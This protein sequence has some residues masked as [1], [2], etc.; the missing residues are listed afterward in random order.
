MR[1]VSNLY[2]TLQVCNTNY[3]I[4]STFKA[5]NNPST[6]GLIRSTNRCEDSVHVQVHGVD[7][8]FKQQT[9]RPFHGRQNSN[10]AP[11]SAVLYC[12]PY[13]VRSTRSCERVCVCD[14]SADVR[15]LES[16][17]PAGGSGETGGS[18]SHHSNS[19]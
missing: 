4:P 11:C 3:H 15:K 2:V 12:T 18:I 9:R 14:G 8:K 7:L 5:S 19:F 13:A 1:G 16:V 6:S 10:M 17:S